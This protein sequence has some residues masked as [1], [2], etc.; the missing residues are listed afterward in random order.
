MKWLG[1]Y[2]Q[3]FTSRFRDDVYLEQGANFIITDNTD[4][5]DSFTI[6]TTTHGTTTLTTIDDDATAA[7]L[8]LD[9][10]GDIILD[11]ATGNTDEGIILKTNG[12]Q[13]GTLAAHHA[14]SHFTLYENAGASL[15]DYFNIAV[16]A[17]GA[18]TL[19]TV[20]A[21]GAEA[22]FEVAS[23]GD[24]TL[25]ANGQIKLEPVAGNN[26]LLDG[27]ITVDAGVV[28]G[29]TSITSTAFVGALTG[30]AESA[31]T[32]ATVTTAVQP[33][34]ESIWT[35]GDSLQILGDQ[36]LIT[37]ASSGM[38]QMTLTNIA[39]DALAPTI[40]LKNQ[41]YDSSTQAGEDGD[42]L[43]TIKFSGYDDQGTPAVQNYAQ[44]YA[45][46]D[47]ATC[48]E[49]SGELF[50][51][52]ANHDGGTGTGLKLT[53]G[54]ENNEIDVTVGLGVNSVT[55]IA[56]SL[57]PK[58]QL[59]IKQ[60]SFSLDPGTDPIYFPMTGTAENTSPNGIAIPM[61]APANGKLLKIH[62]RSNKDHSD[63]NQTFTLHNWDDDEQFTTGLISTLGAKTVTG[64]AH[65]NVITIDFQSSLDSG[66]NA[67][68][69]GEMVAI[70]V[71]NASDLD[72]GTAKYLYTAVFEFDF[73]GY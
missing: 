60:G 24:I 22:N 3:N 14:G 8:V 65:N 58:G 6:R 34:I 37:N 42:Y 39:D 47:D 64:V 21:S 54:S 51:N 72:E 49:E 18:T 56:G 7:H 23:G 44:I 59:F 36:V 15:V 69:A 31:T 2:I 17:G 32:A 19:T 45:T 63:F 5:G 53:G 1:Q 29:A 38:P 28:T 43:G 57:R 9:A 12:T 55:T 10:D 61:I 66:T 40:I 4:P 30:N 46:I 41:R 27:T 68:T 26:I 50:F 71:D 48:G 20:D 73:T 13:F 11:A 25:D 52:I 62:F 16:A 35:D 67:F 70:S 33:A